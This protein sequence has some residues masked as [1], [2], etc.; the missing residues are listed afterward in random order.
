MNKI[1]DNIIEGLNKILAKI[2]VVA[3]RE[4]LENL[5]AGT[6]VKNSMIEINGIDTAEREIFMDT[7]AQKLTGNLWPCNGDS[8]DYSKSFLKKFVEAVEK[9]EGLSFLPQS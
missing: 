9:E 4:Y 5:L 1:P 8:D 3:T 7:L 2:Q 6:R